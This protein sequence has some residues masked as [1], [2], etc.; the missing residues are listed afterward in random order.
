MFQD[1]TMAVTAL[2]GVQN[3]AEPVSPQPPLDP[4]APEYWRN[5]VQKMSEERKLLMAENQ[6]LR[7]D[8][9]DSERVHELRTLQESVIKEELA[10]LW[11]SQKRSG[12]DADYVKNVLVTAIHAGEL[13]V[14]DSMIPV[15][16]TIFSLSADESNK[17]K[18][19]KVKHQVIKGQQRQ[20]S[21]SSSGKG[22]PKVAG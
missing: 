18:E 7:R 8:V 13:I 3:P 15:L 19:P 2:M 12:V 14:L 16:Q 22:S 9:Q 6:I 11:R 20:F 5:L 10:E 1:V 17:I 21:R 4:N